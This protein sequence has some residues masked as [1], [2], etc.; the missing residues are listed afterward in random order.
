MNR[1]CPNCNK[2]VAESDIYCG[3]CYVVLLA[4]ESGEGFFAIVLRYL[5]SNACVLAVVYVLVALVVSPVSA[6]E[7][8]PEAAKTVLKRNITGFPPQGHTNPDCWVQGLTS[9]SAERLKAR[10]LAIGRD[11]E[12]QYGLDITQ[13]SR[14]LVVSD[15]SLL[16]TTLHL[17]A[18]G[19]AANIGG[20][21]YGAG[22]SCV[23]IEIGNTHV[24]DT[25]RHEWAH[26]AAFRRYGTMNHGPE[27]RAV[28][29]A[30]G[31]DTSGY[32]HCG[33]RDLDCIRSQ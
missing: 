10:A 8:G 31:A 30:F 29:A 11:L 33:R 4:K 23:I 15:I 1:H 32:E 24:E 12:H 13:R 26:I 19:V 18:A 21:I 6:L 28:A 22:E 9:P 25:I 20:S 17:N 7:N 14:V 3:H 27:W 5:V 16:K 2:E